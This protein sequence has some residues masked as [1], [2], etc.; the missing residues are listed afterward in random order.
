VAAVG[1]AVEF[2]VAAGGPGCPGGPAAA[3]QFTGH[4]D[5]AQSTP[6]GENG[7]IGGCLLAGGPTP[8]FRDVQIISKPLYCPV[9]TRWQV[10]S[11]VVMLS[12]AD[13]P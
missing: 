9:S 2:V 7:A 8:T 3:R 11:G 12:S 1:L 5:V 10:A 4:T 6:L 13:L